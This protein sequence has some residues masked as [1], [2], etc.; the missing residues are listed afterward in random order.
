M[1]NL[2]IVTAI[3]VCIDTVAKAFRNHDEAVAYA[4]KLEEEDFS[5]SDVT[6]V[7]KGIR[8]GYSS[9]CQ[10]DVEIQIHETEL[11]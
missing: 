2:F 1:E 3:G 9:N 11:S 4:W 6:A 5:M 10:C 8:K 7:C